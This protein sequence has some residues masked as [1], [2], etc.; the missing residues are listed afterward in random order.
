MIRGDVVE[1]VGKDRHDSA[2]LE[3]LGQVVEDEP[4]VRL[5]PRGGH[6]EQVEH[7][8]ELRRLAGRLQV[9][10]HRV[11]EDAP[12]RPSPAAGGSCRPAPPR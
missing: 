7:L 11:V 3:P 6:V 1:Q 5:L 2:L 4:Q 8:L 10:A 9:A 12:G